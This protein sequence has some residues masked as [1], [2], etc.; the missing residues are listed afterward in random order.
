VEGSA[1]WCGIGSDGIQKFL[2]AQLPIPQSEL[3]RFE[4]DQGGGKPD[5]E[6]KE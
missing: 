3:D 6:R 1:S 4:K 5:A 2:E